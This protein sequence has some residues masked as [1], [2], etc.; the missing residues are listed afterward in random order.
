MLQ[1]AMIWLLCHRV[2][3]RCIDVGFGIQEVGHLQTVR[4]QQGLKAL[5]TVQISSYHTARF[6]YFLYTKKQDE[7]IR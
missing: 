3:I 7:S 4:N 5:R 1:D 2:L 6:Y